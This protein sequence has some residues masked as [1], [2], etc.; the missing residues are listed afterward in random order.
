MSSCRP[1]SSTPAAMDIM[2]RFL[3]A[4]YVSRGMDRER[5]QDK[6]RQR[7]EQLVFVMGKNCAISYLDKLVRRQ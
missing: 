2:A 6:G 3:A 1:A 7:A 4:Q 5:A